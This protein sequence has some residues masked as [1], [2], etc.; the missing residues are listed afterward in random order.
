MKLPSHI[1]LNIHLIGIGGIGISGI[2]E[3]LHNLGHAVQGSD[4]SDNANT[5]RL[6]KL[7]ISVFIG[8]RSENLKNA[9]IVVISSGVPE[10]NEELIAAREM[11]LPVLKRAEMLAEIMRF[12]FSVAVAGTHGKTTTTSMNAALLDAAKLD[13]TVINGGIINSLNTNARLGTGEWMVVEADESDG[14]FTKIP[15]TIGIITNIDPEHLDYYGSFEALK[16]AFYTFIHNLPFYGLGVLCYEHPLVKELAESITDRRITTYGFSKEASIYAYN[17]KP[18]SEGTYFD[19]DI[20]LRHTPFLKHIHKEITV[21]PKRYK[22]LFLPMVGEHNVLNFLSA[23]AVAEELGI[24]EQ[25]IRET[26]NNFQGV[27]RRF[28]K[29]ADIQ[30]VKIIDDYAHH[31]TEIKTVIK[32]ARQCA[33]GRVIAVLQPHRYSRVRD[34]FEEFTLC[35]EG[36]DELILLPIYEAGEKPIE[37]ISSATLANNTKHKR[38]YEAKDPEDLSLYLSNLALPG[39]IILCMGAGNIT[40]IAH[41]LPEQLS[42]K[43]Q[44]EVA[45]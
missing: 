34:L 8:H 25:A 22:S 39:D 4:Q 43:V 1:K 20:S 10:S 2:A 36:A 13:P 37:G 30:G 3:I 9:D 14:T 19:V 16:A 6:K 31:P 41:A 35:C 29:V 15:A 17:L 28:S 21:P 7:G 44:K 23:I 32:A 11:H 5:H 12:G 42:F 38:V 26:L 40:A 24:S 33:K 18:T 27:K 45:L